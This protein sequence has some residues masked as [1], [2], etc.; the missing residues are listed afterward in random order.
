LFSRAPAYRLTV[1]KKREGEFE[2][3]KSMLNHKRAINMI[4]FL[5]LTTCFL[6]LMTTMPTAHAGYQNSGKSHTPNLTEFHVGDTITFTITVSVLESLGGPPLSISNLTITDPLPVGETFVTGSDTSTPSSSFTAYPNGTN[7]ILFWDFGKGPFA[8]TLQAIVS[9][10]IT[11]DS[12]APSGPLYDYATINYDETLS[13]G[14][15]TPQVTD[16]IQVAPAPA[17]SLTKTASPSTPQTAPANFTYTYVVTNTGDEALFNVT[18]YD[19]TFNH[20]ILGPVPLPVGQS[21]TGHYGPHSITTNGTVFT[22]YA[23]ATGTDQTGAVVNAFAQ[24]TVSTTTPPPPPP[25]PVGGKVEPANTPMVLFAA[26]EDTL[27]SNYW[28][29]VLAVGAIAALIIFKRRRN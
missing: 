16:N 10:N 27:V 5:A 8:T 25:R 29:A 9:Y 2:M 24:A 15:S 1:R 20:L 6:A 17:I 26:I 11:V 22:N 21:A 7:Y 19:Q 3:N 4:S 12:N 14:H 28:V 13:G 18:I 23:N